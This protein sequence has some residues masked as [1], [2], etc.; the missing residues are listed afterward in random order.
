MSEPIWMS[1]EIGG[2]IPKRALKE[3]LGLIENSMNDITGVF[4]IKDISGLKPVWWSGFSNYGECDEIKK[5]CK[6]HKLSY[7]HHSDSVPGEMDA[8]LSWW[9]PD[10]KQETRIYA[11]QDGDPVVSIYEIKPLINLLLAYYKDGEKVLPLFINNDEVKDII[12]KGF[13]NPKKIL[14]AL[15]KKFKSLMPDI[16]KIPPLRIRRQTNGRTNS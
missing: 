10:M 1:I 8:I 15:E 14:P 16:P 5:L 4:E 6:K 3:L 7:L 11:S 2:D 9:T 13:K 12:E